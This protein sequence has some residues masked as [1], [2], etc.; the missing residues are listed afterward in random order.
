MRPTEQLLPSLIDGD[1]DATVEL[2]GG[3]GDVSDPLTGRQNRPDM[4]YFWAA[5]RHMWLTDHKARLRPVAVVAGP[6]ATVVESV[7]ELELD[8]KRVDLPVAVVGEE[9]G[10]R[11]RR[12]RIYHSEWPLYGRHRV[13][14]PL[15]PPREELRPA[16]A[17]GVYQAALA[18]GDL[19]GILGVF[20]ED[21]VAREPSGGAYVYDTP[22][23]RREFYGAILKAGGIRLLHCSITDDGTSCA[24]EYIVT[25]WGETP[26]PP[27][28]GVAVYVRAGDRLSAARIYDDVSPP[29]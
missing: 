28:A 6:E 10:D 8:G 16:G 9:E 4:F 27:Q 23:R 21:A 17:V 12:A 29:E 11:I 1:T 24:I 7:L 5:A 14:G 15:I 26:L 13:R 18:A 22:D 2:F 3:L 25:R 20:T 19:E